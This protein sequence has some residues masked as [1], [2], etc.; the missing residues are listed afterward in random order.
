[1]VTPARRPGVA[2]AERR[3]RSR[4]RLGARGRWRAPYGTA[5][6]P[7]VDKIVGPGNQWVAA[8]KRMVF[9]QVDIDS[10]AG[11]S[12]VMIIADDTADPAWVAA[13][14]IAQAEHDVEA[15]PILVTTAAALPAAVER[16]LEDQLATLPRAAIARAALERHGVAVVVDSLDAAIAVANRYAPEHLQL[17]VAD[18]LVPQVTPPARCSSASGP[19]EA[20]GDSWPAPITCCRG[21]A[22]ATPARSASMTSAADRS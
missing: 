4:V 12:E 8:A 16:A 20:A 17:D 9:G 6:V 18:P 14:L 19:P 1:M 2:A 15:R 5:T 13:D 7:R 21:G 22:A 11:P 3:R 10:V